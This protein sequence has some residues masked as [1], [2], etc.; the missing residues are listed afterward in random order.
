[1]SSLLFGQ[2][3]ICLRDKTQTSSIVD[4][5]FVCENQHVLY[6]TDTWKI[7]CNKVL[8]YLQFSKNTKF[9]RIVLNHFYQLINPILSAKNENSV[10]EW[11]FVSWLHIS[12]YNVVSLN[13][14]VS[15]QLPPEENC[16]LVMVWVWVKVRISFR[17]GGGGNQTVALKKSC[18]SV[19]VRVWLRV[20]FGV[21]E[22]FSTG[23]IILEPI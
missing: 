4:F 22:Q 14:T 23:A 17:V 7:D 18:P 6:C 12:F 5:Y 20:S 2:R 16:P 11:R 13:V 21:G 10:I 15:G 19:R 1:M 9:V 3:T 8:C